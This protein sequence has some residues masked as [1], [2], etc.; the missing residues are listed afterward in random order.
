MYE[1]VGFKVA[2]QINMKDVCMLMFLVTS[3][4][5]G[6]HLL[7]VLGKIVSND[8]SRNSMISIIKQ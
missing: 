5:V 3:L 6:S 1:L 2:K 7:E 8:A 4:L